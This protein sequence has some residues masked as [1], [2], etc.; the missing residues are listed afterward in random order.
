[1]KAN[2]TSVRAGVQDLLCPFDKMFITQGA[3]VGSHKGTE[4]IDVRGE[5]RGVK[6]PYYAPCDLKVVQI[7][8]NS[9]T[10]LWQSVKPVRLANGKVTHITIVTAHDNTINFGVGFNI[11][12]GQQMG[13]MGDK[14]IGT[15]V[16]AHIEQ[17]YGLQTTF[18]KNGQTFNLGGKNYAIYGLKQQIPFEEAY[19]MDN[20]EI[21]SGKANWK[22]L[23]DVEVNEYE[24]EVWSFTSNANQNINI[25]EN[26]DTKAKIVGKLAKGQTYNYIQKFND[27]KYVW[28]S[29]GKTWL[30][31]REVKNGKRQALWGT[32]Q[33][34]K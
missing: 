5:V 23:K 2:Q 7:Y 27:G 4:A 6:N 10:V 14:G 13:N 22:Y 1:M 15:G 32:L 11:K 17:G 26:H 19:F 33:A 16:H 18:D 24:K 12:Q 20:T 9:A 34:Q 29:N 28:V 25:R 21:I 8:Y 30:A 3:N 31:V